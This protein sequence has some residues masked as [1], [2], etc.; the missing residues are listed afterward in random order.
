MAAYFKL[1]KS[2]S[3][4]SSFLSTVYRAV[5]IRSR[6]WILNSWPD[7]NW[8]LL[9]SDWLFKNNN[10]QATG[11]KQPNWAS[12]FDTECGQKIL[13]IFQYVFSLTKSTLFR[14][15]ED[16]EFPGQILYWIRYRIS[17]SNWMD[18]FPVVRFFKRHF[19]SQEIKLFLEQYAICKLA[20]PTPHSFFNFLKSRN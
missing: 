17:M 12:Y 9:C 16:I 6:A 19:C 13:T 11:K 1:V 10:K 5:P 18:L 15:R 14:N 20:R 8:G 4:K 7:R 2:R 3:R